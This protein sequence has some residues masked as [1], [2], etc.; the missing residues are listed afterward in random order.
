MRALEAEGLIL[1]FAVSV[2]GPMERACA[3]SASL[4]D[5]SLI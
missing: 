5:F 2:D 1:G 4:V 3:D